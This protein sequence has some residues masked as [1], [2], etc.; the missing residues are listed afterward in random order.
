MSDLFGKPI[1][2]GK[3]HTVLLPTNVVQRIHAIQKERS[4]GFQNH[5]RATLN[6]LHDCTALDWD[7]TFL[8]QTCRYAWLYGT[9]GWQDICKSIIHAIKEGEQHDR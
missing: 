6:R 8:G 9:G 7:D 1:V 4:G 3:Q 5:A 2:E